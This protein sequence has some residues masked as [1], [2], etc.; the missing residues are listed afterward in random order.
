V[1][2]SSRIAA[3]NAAPRAL[4]ALFPAKPRD[5][6]AVVDV[7][8]VSSL[9]GPGDVTT[10]APPF[11]ALTAF[12]SPGATPAPPA[13]P[14]TGAPLEVAA[15]PG[16]AAATGA[17]A[18]WFPDERFTSASFASTAPRFAATSAFVSAAGFGFVEFLG[19]EFR[20]GACLSLASAVLGDSFAAAPLAP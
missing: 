8:D 9:A 11:D 6:L 5:N 7:T 2:A 16:R 17:S 3:G 18:L 4:L 19:F 14:A 20:T 1:P 12:V 10:G 13:P 15:S